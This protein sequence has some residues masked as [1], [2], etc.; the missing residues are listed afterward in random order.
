VVG[1]GEG[2]AQ[3]GSH[4]SATQSVRPKAEAPRPM[5]RLPPS[6]TADAIDA[7]V[8][9][10]DRGSTSGAWKATQ[11]TH[12]CHA[13]HHQA[14]PRLRSSAVGALRS[15]PAC[16]WWQRGSARTHLLRC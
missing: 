2:A 14:V 3:P 5:V 11:E 4:Q 7:A 1:G 15:L 10:A 8:V 12:C 6:A 13:W 9:G 16:C